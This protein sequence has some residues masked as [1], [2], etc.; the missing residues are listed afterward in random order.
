MNY[1]SLY[2][3]RNGQYMRT[4][5]QRFTSPL[6][7]RS[8]RHSPS[9][10]SSPGRQS[11]KE[12]CKSGTCKVNDSTSSSQPEKYQK[13]SRDPTEWGPHLWSFMHFAAANYPEQPTHKEIQDMVSWLCTLY[14][15]IPCENCQIHY[16]RH[17]ENAKP[18]LPRICSNK[19]DLFNFL[20]DIHNDVNKRNKKPLVSYE[21]ARLIF[22]RRRH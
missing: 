1:R 12:S 22:P 3:G 4:S 14:V 9:P 13:W 7:Q 10:P 16:K 15:T 5:S 6:R 17:I 21:H 18:Y 20:V 2:S 11:E 19:D 8:P